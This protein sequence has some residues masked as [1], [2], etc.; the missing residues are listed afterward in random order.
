MRRSTKE[1]WAYGAACA[2][3]H[4]G[5]GMRRLPSASRWFTRT[6]R[7]KELD[8]YSSSMVKKLEV[9]HHYDTFTILLH[10]TTAALVVLLWG[11]A[12]PDI[13]MAG[14][15]SF[16]DFFPKGQP[17]IMVRSLHIALGVVLV[18]VLLVRLFWRGTS[19]RKLPPADQGLL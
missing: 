14:G 15:V 13:P 9:P 1:D 16:I 8:V 4:G 6:C 2:F 11:M 3:T 19:G 17:R 5:F 7:E 10:W 18:A 12:S